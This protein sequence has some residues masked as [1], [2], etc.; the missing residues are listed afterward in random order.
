MTVQLISM[1]VFALF[2]LIL[3]ERKLYNLRVQVR[4]L[5]QQLDTAKHGPSRQA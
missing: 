3:Y 1:L 2:S 5:E 4:N